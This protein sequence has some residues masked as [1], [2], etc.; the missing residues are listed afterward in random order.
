M[1]VFFLFDF[2]INIKYLLHI[3]W[4]RNNYFLSTK[5][6]DMCPKIPTMKRFPYDYQPV[7]QRFITCL[8]I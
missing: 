4:N 5:E 7:D 8:L 2:S 1:R 6:M 3:E